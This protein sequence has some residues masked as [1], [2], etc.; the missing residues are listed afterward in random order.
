MKK[1]GAYLLAFLFAFNIYSIS[2]KALSF[3]NNMLLMDTG[4]NEVLGSPTDPESTY[5][6]LQ[7]VFTVMKF[8]APVLVLAFSVIEFMKAVASQDK[9]ILQKAIKHTVIRGIC[10]LLVFMVPIIFDFIFELLGWY[11][12]C[13][14]G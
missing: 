11:G 8:A 9:E 6:L 2:A 4:C 7:Q 1:I 14:I 3:N 10:G 13:G 5:V 12:T